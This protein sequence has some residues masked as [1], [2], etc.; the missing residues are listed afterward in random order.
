MPRVAVVVAVPFRRLR[1][2]SLSTATGL[3][4]WSDAA[5]FYCSPLP[6][7]PALEVRACGR[8]QGGK[9]VEAKGANHGRFGDP[10]TRVDT[11][12]MT[13]DHFSW[14]MTCEV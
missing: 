5:T 11:V 8:K 14:D 7:Q 12:G 13:R 9:G 2:V 4:Y 3:G 6:A 1:R 10:V